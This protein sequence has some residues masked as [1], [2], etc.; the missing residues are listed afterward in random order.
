RPPPVPEH[1]AFPYRNLY[2]PPAILSLLGYASTTAFRL[3]VCL[4]VQRFLPGLLCAVQ[5][6]FNYRLAAGV[7][8]ADLCVFG[9]FAE[10]SERQIDHQLCEIGEFLRLD[11]DDI[12]AVRF[13]EQLLVCADAIARFGQAL[14]VRLYPEAAGKRHFRQR[15]RQPALRAVVTAY[16]K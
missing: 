2:R 14:Q 4:P 13:A 9:D 11:F 5:F 6:R 7:L 8:N 10:L 12:S 1:A 16:R 3:R 15:Y